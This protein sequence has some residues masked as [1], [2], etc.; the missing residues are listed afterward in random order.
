MDAK[1]CD[2]CGKFYDKQPHKKYILIEKIGPNRFEMDLCPECYSK[3]ESFLENPIVE[4]VSM[5][6]DEQ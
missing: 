3:I 4:E 5:T 1:K 2:R 6:E